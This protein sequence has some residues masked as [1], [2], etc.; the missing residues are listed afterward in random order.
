[1]VEIWWKSDKN[2]DLYYMFYDGLSRPIL[3][4]GFEKVEKMTKFKKKIF[5]RENFFFISFKIIWNG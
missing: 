4:G 3:T 1:M 2:C 5:T